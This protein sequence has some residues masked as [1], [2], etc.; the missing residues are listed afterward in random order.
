MQRRKFKRGK[1][2]FKPKFQKKLKLQKDVL[3]QKLEKMKEKQERI[4]RT[5]PDVDLERGTKV[6]T[7][8]PKGASGRILTSTKIVM[9]QDTR[10][11]SEI[12]RG[13]EIIVTVDPLSFK[14]ESRIVT[15]IMGDRSL[16]INEPF[17]KNVI[18]Y[19][20]FEV[21]KSDKVVEGDQT[22]DQVYKEKIKNFGKRVDRKKHFVEFRK[23]NGMWS[24]KTQKLE[25]DHE[26]SREEML[27]LRVKSQKGTY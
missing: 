7:F 16:S 27:D 22:V 18:S 2:K 6:L 4:T 12:E 3:K 9:G 10:F 15:M 14:K 1:L 21:K 13:D 25:F 8:E 20:Q 5:I 26:L 24:Y 17:S 11:L 23:K 19:S